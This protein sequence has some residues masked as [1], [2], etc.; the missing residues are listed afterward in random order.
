MELVDC[1]IGVYSWTVVHALNE[2]L[3]LPSDLDPSIKKFTSRV[4]R[5]LLR[6]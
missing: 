4:V 5:I 1:G 2:L 6:L 3:F